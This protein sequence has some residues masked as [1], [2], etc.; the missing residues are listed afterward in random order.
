MWQKFFRVPPASP[1][2]P[3]LHLGDLAAVPELWKEEAGIHH[4]DWRKIA[5]L[6]NQRTTTEPEREAAWHDVTAQWLD[7]LKGELGAG[8]R[9]GE[10]RNFL[11][12]SSKSEQALQYFL[13]QCESA[14]AQLRAR[15]GTAAWHWKYGKHAVVMFEDEDAYYRYVSHFFPNDGEYGLSSGMCISGRGYCH[16]VVASAADAVPTLVHEL[17]HLCL[18]PWSL[19]MWLSEGLATHHERALTSRGAHVIDRE[20]IARQRAFWDHG[21]I[22]R[23]WTGKSFRVGEE[24]E[25]SYGLA[26]HLVTLLAREFR[27]L[28]PFVC[29]V[30]REDAGQAAAR[31]HF[32]LDLADIAAAFLGEGDWRWDPPAAPNDD[33]G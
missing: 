14:L 13:G 29:A 9:V 20:S 5:T 8:F 16:T 21:R 17:T 32:D 10:S 23:F 15:L 28:G 3:P 33:Q 2:G 6:V 4:P 11:L 1:V 26:E 7:R 24:R 25:L 31:E 27:E 19:P 12:V 30:R 22:Q 18:R